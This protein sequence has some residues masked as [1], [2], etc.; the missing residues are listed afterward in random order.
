MACILSKP[1]KMVIEGCF[2]ANNKIRVFLQNNYSKDTTIL[3]PMGLV[4][5]EGI[6]RGHAFFGSTHLFWVSAADQLIL[7][8]KS[9]HH[10]TYHTSPFHPEH[11][12]F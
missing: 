4:E 2:Y 9:D 8:S 11:V 10:A 6:R 7:H 3:P 5:W 12:F 1:A